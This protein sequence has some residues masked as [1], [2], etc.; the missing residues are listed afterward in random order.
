MEPPFSGLYADQDVDSSC[1]RLVSAT[2]PQ[3]RNHI[4][5][6]RETIESI[7]EALYLGHPGGAEHHASQL[8]EFPADLFFSVRILKVAAGALAQ[9]RELAA[10]GQ[11]HGHSRRLEA[12]HVGAELGIL[13]N[14][15]PP[16]EGCDFGIPHGLVGEGVITRG[17]S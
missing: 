17:A 12:R 15:D 1:L 14:A 16:T 3:G 8:A 7:D 4:S 6:P 11:R 10:I 5:Q 9:P 13:A 2:V